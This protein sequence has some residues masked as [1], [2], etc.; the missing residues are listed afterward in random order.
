MFTLS[1]ITIGILYFIVGNI[2]AWFQFNSQFVWKWWE[3]KPLF[4]NLIFAIPMGIC[5]WHAI[6]HVVLATGELW[7]SKLIGFGVSNFVFGIMTYIFLSE[8]IFT[9]KTLSCLILA[10]V[11]IGIQ[12]YWK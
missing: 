3:N 10:M 5:F 7:A 12:V 11:I 8:S 4:S 2:L 6:R 9:F 1:N